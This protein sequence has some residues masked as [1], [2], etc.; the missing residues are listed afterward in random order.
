MIWVLAAP[1]RLVE[2]A[3]D[4]AGADLA[5]LRTTLATEFVF[6]DDAMVQLAAAL[7]AVPLSG[8]RDL[9]FGEGE[10]DPR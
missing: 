9:M 2:W 6:V 8:A 7:G 3:G 5:Q 1:Q 4:G 10:I